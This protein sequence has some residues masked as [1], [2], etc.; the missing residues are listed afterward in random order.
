MSL[1]RG[2]SKVA[3]TCASN[4]YTCIS[5]LEG[6]NVTCV[7]VSLDIFIIDTI[8]LSKLLSN[9]IIIVDYKK[10]K[11]NIVDP[12]TKRLNRGSV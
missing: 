12:Q 8:P 7:M 2:F 1:L 10:S 4:L 3:K 6:H 9:G 5:Q 11:D